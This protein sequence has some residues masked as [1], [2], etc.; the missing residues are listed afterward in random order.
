ME[1]LFY[2]MYDQKVNIWFNFEE[3][4]QKSSISGNFQKL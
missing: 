4:I 3:K 2:T 1:Q